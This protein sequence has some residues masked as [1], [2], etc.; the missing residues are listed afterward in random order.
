[1]S[2]QDRKESNITIDKKINWP[3][4]RAQKRSNT[5]FII[6]SPDNLVGVS[7]EIMVERQLCHKVPDMA[8]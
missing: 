2:S 5:T 4:K 1:M 7:F 8:N 6:R 3:Q